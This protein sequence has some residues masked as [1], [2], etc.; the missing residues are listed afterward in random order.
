[1][2]IREEIQNRFIIVL[3]CRVA[4]A[5]QVILKIVEY[6]VNDSIEILFDFLQWITKPLF[7]ENLQ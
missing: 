5:I 7:F 1:M 4:Y 6:Q 2:D 3:H